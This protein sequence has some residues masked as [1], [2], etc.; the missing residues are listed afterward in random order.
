MKGENGVGAIV[1]KN[2]TVNFDTGSV[3]ELQGSGVGLFGQKGAVINDNG[4]T[5]NNNGHSAERIRITGGIS[6]TIANT[7]LTTGNVL[8]HVINGEAVIETGVTANSTPTS[9]NIIGL[10]VE[11]NR[12][13]N[14]TTVNW[15]Y[16]DTS[17]PENNYD[18][19]NLGTID[20]TNS[21]SATGMYLESARGKNS[22]EIKVGD[23]S[24]GIYG[25]YKNETSKF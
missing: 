19:I 15:L 13:D 2:A 18:T 6:R 14:D 1:T 3:I 25:V 23:N 4:G 10:L 8:T 5:F 11:G 22:G 9:Q 12:D 7:T 21:T 17:N 16:K 20:F 24:T